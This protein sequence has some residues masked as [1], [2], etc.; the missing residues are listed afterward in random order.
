MDEEK[1]VGGCTYRKAFTAG[2]VCGVWER[3][4]AVGCGGQEAYTN[5]LGDRVDFA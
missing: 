1:R 2:T 4:P 5:F 3:V